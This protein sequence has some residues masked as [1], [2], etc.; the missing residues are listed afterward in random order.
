[1][2]FRHIKHTRP[3]LQPAASHFD[4]SMEKRVVLD[5]IIFGLQQFGGVSNYWAKLVGFSSASPSFEFTLILPKNL[6]YS[7]FNNDWIQ[8]CRVRSEICSSTVSR[9][10]PV[11]IPANSGV[12]HTSYYRLPLNSVHKYVVTVYDFIYERYRHNLPRIIHSTQKFASISRADSIICISHSTRRDLLEFCPNIDDAKISVVPLGVDL[13][14]FFVPTDW[15]PEKFGNCVLFVG[16][17]R[18]YK[19]FDLAIEAVR[20][21]PELKLGV[22]G[23]ILSNSERDILNSRLG[24]R[25]EEYGPVPTSG[26]RQLYASAFAFIFPSDCEGF[27]LPLL[28]AMACGCPVVAANSSS[29]PEIGGDA[30]SYASGQTGEAFAS[31]LELLKASTVRQEYIRAGLLRALE[32]SWRR[33]CI[34]TINV[35]SS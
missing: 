35:Y 1:M 24:T 7:D 31:K 26:L 21:L 19:R 10:F 3:P 33:A 12:F 9:Y 5:C 25:W 18:G 23:T 20:Q 17:R 16:Q 30:A 22:V 2:N 29:L 34:E 32:Y 27:G 28:E 13:D 14:S 8:R 4:Q 6:T 15:H 11:S